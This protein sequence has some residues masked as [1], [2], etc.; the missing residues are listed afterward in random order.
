[1]SVFLL[2]NACSSFS[3]KMQK[4]FP[5]ASRRND[6]YSIGFPLYFTQKIHKI[7]RRFAPELSI[8]Y[9]ISFVFCPQRP[10]IPPALR[11]GM[12][13][14]PLD[15]LCI[16]PKKAQNFPGASRRNGNHSIGVPLYLTKKGQN[17]SPALRAGMVIIALDF[18]CILPKM[19]KIPPAL[20][21]GMVII[22]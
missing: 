20:R 5:G 14:I 21:A 19:P 17:Y 7:P 6:H 22:P 9:R 4:T 12:V 2:D 13:I 1:M 8:L 18:L 3:T 11:A 16:P 10:K 15:F